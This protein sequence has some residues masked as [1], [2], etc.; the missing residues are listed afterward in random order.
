MPI[1]EIPGG[2]LRYTITGSMDH[3]PL[4]LL[5]PQSRGP[6]GIR[7][8]MDALARHRCII[9]Y[10][11]RGTGDSSEAPQELS[12]ATQAEDLIGLL[13]A[14]D[15][16]ETALL[17]HSTGCGIGISTAARSPN[18]ISSLILASPWTHADPHLHTMQHLR[19]AAAG[20]LE[21][22]QY[23]HFN[24]ALLYPPDYRRAHQDG[25]A[26]GAADARSSPQDADQ[27]AGRLQAIL[28]FDA[29]PLLPKI[30]ART[31]VIAARDDQLMPAWFGVEAADLLP[32][33]QLVEFDGGGHMLL[34]TQMDSIVEN[35]LSFLASEV[36]ET[37]IITSVRDGNG[38][39]R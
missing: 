36:P 2:T 33:G 30:N 29:R 23:A 3:E 12:M 27:I 24:A 28:A 26:R 22:E 8:L 1:A 39:V 38:R 4:V 16:S 17:C 13:D 25:F 35:V 14:L 19:I 21:P 10:D 15:I 32:D 11:Q 7:P 20:A 9:T 5:L 18:R 31:M 37:Q 34:E 6:V